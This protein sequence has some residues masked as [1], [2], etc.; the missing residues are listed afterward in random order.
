VKPFFGMSFV[1][2]CLA[3]VSPSAIAYCPSGMQCGSCSDEYH[4][5]YYGLECL[6]QQCDLDPTGDFC[7]E[8][9]FDDCVGIDPKTQEPASVQ[10]VFCT[11]AWDITWPSGGSGDDSGDPDSQD[12]GC[13]ISAEYSRPCWWP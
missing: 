5:T 13:G 2:A 9:H 12:P 7:C 8:Q 1:A 11:Q 4:C 3:I 10:A 6:C